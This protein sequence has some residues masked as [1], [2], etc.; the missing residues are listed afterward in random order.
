[1]SRRRAR[2]IGGKG[3]PPASWTLLVLAVGG[4]ISHGCEVATEADR[5]ETHSCLASIERAY[6][7]HPVAVKASISSGREWVRLSDTETDALLMAIAHE[8]PLDCL[9]WRGG[10]PLVDHWENRVLV[11]ARHGREGKVEIRT[12]SKGP[13]R[14][15]RTADDITGA[16]LDPLKQR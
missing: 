10:E 1:M 3:N 6:V 11:E 7:D 8:T 15:E 12:W 4:V 14:Q 5:A 2:Y 16:D 13:D 9:G